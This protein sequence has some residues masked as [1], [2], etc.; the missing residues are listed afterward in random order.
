ME[1][2]LESFKMIAWKVQLASSLKIAI[3]AKAKPQTVTLD[4]CLKA[5]TPTRRGLTKLL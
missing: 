2:K 3:F 5:V 1:I 4:K